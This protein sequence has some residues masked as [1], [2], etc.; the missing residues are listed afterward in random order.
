MGAPTRG[1]GW[2]HSSPIPGAPEDASAE[3][4]TILLDQAVLI[5]FNALE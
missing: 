3:V 5:E 1:E 2:L 4:V